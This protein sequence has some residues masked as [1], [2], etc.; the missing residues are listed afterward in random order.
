MNLNGGG[1]SCGGH[2]A[3]TTNKPGVA[4]AIFKMSLPAAIA[5]GLND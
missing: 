5:A 1:A 3:N 4:K 2:L